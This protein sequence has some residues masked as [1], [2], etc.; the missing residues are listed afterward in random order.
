M[1]MECNRS[2]RSSLQ[3]NWPLLLSLPVLTCR[4]LSNSSPQPDRP[5]KH[6]LKAWGQ[7]Q[8]QRWWTWLE[9]SA[10]RLHTTANLGTG[11]VPECSSL[12]HPWNVF[13][14]PRARPLMHSVSFVHPH[15]C[16]GLLCLGQNMYST[17]N[18][19]PG[20]QHRPATLLSFQ[21]YPW[22]IIRKCQKPHSKWF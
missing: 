11:S 9:Q 2:T 10:Q 22:I 14:G 5:E 3:L 4:F 7:E 1:K 8:G 16:S 18:S 6:S 19:S 21:D 20:W 13:Q 12:P 15:D 17:S